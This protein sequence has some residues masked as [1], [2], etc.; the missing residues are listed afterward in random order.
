MVPRAL[1]VSQLVCVIIWLTYQSPAS[2]GVFD[3]AANKVIASGTEVD[4]APADEEAMTIADKLQASKQ[5]IL[6][7]EEQR[8]KILGSIYVINKRM[9]K[10][11]IEKGHFTNQL[12]QVQDSTKGIAKI[13]AGL[14]EQISR[15]R[16]QLRMRLRELYKLSG[17]SYIG[18][19]FSQSS[20]GDL[21]EVLRFLKIVT[22][23]DY[24][25]I[26]SYKENIA[27]Y[28][29]QKDRLH[30]QIQ[31]LVGIEKNIRNQE[32]QL[33]E[34]HKAKSKIVSKLDRQ[35]IANLKQLQNL[36]S[37]SREISSTGEIPS[38]ST[39]AS[40]LA[41]LLKPSIYE[42]KGQLASP[43]QG[44]VV[45]D[46]GLIVDEKY[47]TRLSHKGWRY[48]SSHEAPV[49]AIFEGTVIFT[50]WVDGYGE[51]VIIDHGD[52]YYSVYGHIARI[53]VKIGDT[54]NKGQAFASSGPAVGPTFGPTVGPLGGRADEDHGEGL[55]FE[56]RHF[57]E[58]ENPVNW[59]LKS[60]VQQAS[61]ANTLQ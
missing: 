36:R 18:I 35:K 9:K 45:Q 12:L 6:E 61:V 52:H 3:R 2:A 31:K 37:K 53:K 34:E 50:G 46:F 16:A 11:S 39:T 8:R 14:E 27:L 43:I 51:T 47:K 24:Q 10:I 59:I 32:T 58:P 21:D 4:S 17:Q 26:K 25:L 20:V 48:H 15:Q 57:S 5:D 41:E 29:K 1:R 38:S 55:Y 19:I 28:Q 54:L 22:D 42:Q 13:V 49:A 30:G 60:P 40:R 33:A 56:I 7:A 23:N 44:E